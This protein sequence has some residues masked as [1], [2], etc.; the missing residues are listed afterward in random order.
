[1]WADLKDGRS[2]GI[3]FL[4]KNILR[5]ITI[6]TAVVD[7]GSA[8]KQGRSSHRHGRLIC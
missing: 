5:H 7:R 1:M 3:P 4:R 8:E 6:S 2:L